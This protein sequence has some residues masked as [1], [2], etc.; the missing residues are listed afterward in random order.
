MQTYARLNENNV[1]L[2]IITVQNGFTIE[3]TIVPELLPSLVMCPSDTVAKSTYNPETLQFTPPPPPPQTWNDYSVR[4]GL[5]L[6]D[7]TKWDNNQTPE[8]ITVKIE[9]EMPQERPYTTELLEYLVASD[10]ISQTSMDQVLAQPSSVS[11]AEE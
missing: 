7:K 9:F 2:E 5:T 11:M 6:T 3:Q 10:S 4:A 8:I 1:V